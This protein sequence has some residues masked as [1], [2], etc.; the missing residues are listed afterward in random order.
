MNIYR[1]RAFLVAHLASIYPS[2]ICYDDPEEP[3]WPVIYIE[4]PEGQMSWHLSGDDLDLFDHAWGK[5]PMSWDGHTTEEKYERL[6]ALT[7]NT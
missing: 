5:R 2:Y 6:R 4:T 7:L 1:E 3:E